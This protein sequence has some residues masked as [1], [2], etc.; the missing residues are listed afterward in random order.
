M[1]YKVFQNPR[2]NPNLFQITMFWSFASGS[3]QGQKKY[4]K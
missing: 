3:G 1:E 2:V 4:I